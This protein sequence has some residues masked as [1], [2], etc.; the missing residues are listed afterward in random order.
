MRRLLTAAWGAAALGA[1]LGLVACTGG[2]YEATPIPGPSTAAAS[3][4][5]S[6]TATT[7]PAQCDD[8]LQSYSPN[9]KAKSALL[10]KIKQRGRLIAGVSADTLLFGARNPVNGQIEGFDIDRLHAVSQAIFGDPD[11][12]EFKVIT[13]AQRIPA[14]QEG[15]VD[16]VARTMT[17]NC[18]RWTQVAFS[19]QYYEAGQKVLVQRDSAARGIR[20][21]SGKKV[22]APKGST[23]LAKLADFPA[24]KAV[25]ADTH[26]GCL[27]QFQQG[28][29]DAITGDDTVLAGLA[30][31]DPYAKVVGEAFSSEP[32]G[33]AMPLKEKGFVQFVNA[34]VEKEK[35][36]GSWQAS[37]NHW[38]RSALGAAPTPPPA[39]FG[40][41]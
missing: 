35:S 4:S 40:R 17:I 24:V 38:L 14:L 25:P 18:D 7:T 1:T 12:I 16:I 26:T 29:V 27:V 8:A 3:G 10:T 20:D 22:C 33:L 19:G 36:D 32:Y 34:V 13:T 39:T 31:Q 5:P 41:E 37:Y 2:A 11:K 6:P 9:A 21:L 23:S 28:Q 30:A 15:D